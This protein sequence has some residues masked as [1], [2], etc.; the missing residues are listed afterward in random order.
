[1]LDSIRKTADSFIM[2]C[3]FGMIA[4]AFI[5]FGIKDV[6]NGGRGG[7]IVTFS[8][9][10]NISQADFLQAKSLEINSINKQ[11]GTSLTDEEIAQLN[12]DNRILKRLIYNNV[13]DYLVSYYDLDLSDDTVKILVKASPVFKNEQ[14]VFDIKIF[15]TYFRNSYMDEEKYLLN[16]KE[17]ALKNIF[18]GIFAESFYIPKAMTENIVDYMAEKREVELVQIDLQNK[19]KDLQIPTPTDQQLK[20]FYQDNKTSFEVPEK[21]SFSYIKANIKDLKVS[22]TQDELLEF[23]NENKDEFGNQSFETVQKQLY[24]LLKAQKID[25]LNMEFAKKLED[26]TVAGASL[27]DIAEK[28]KL[29]IHNVN[30]VS[31][32][33]LI[34]DEII[35]GNADSIFELS[36]GELSYPIEAEDKSYLMLV[37]LKSIQ[38]TKIPEFDS[39]KEQVNKVWI[40]QHIADVNLNIIKDLAKEYNS[41]QEN[42]KEFKA[43]GIKIS[44]KNY[45]RSEIENELSLT[46]EILLSI[47]NTKIGSNTPVFQVGDEVYFA[48]I[49]SR[50]IDELTAKNIRFNSEKSIIYNIKNSIIDEL[51]NYA[52]IQNDM[53]VNANFSK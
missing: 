38:P 21:R 20:D 43:T 5:V 4:F 51:I 46:P 28:Y 41:D 11:T 25:I 48:H 35:A 50:S 10:K 32:A 29:P 14:G 6:L 22:V 18:V 33:E 44:K 19:P 15:K 47:F 2:R 9:A 27:I 36:E 17:K 12:I 13:L 49:K 37:E 52:I 1:M 45:I 39:I 3:L 26:E 8:H 23:Y 53:R 30:Y 40:K 24:D 42:I 31:Y 16:F 7:D 34:E